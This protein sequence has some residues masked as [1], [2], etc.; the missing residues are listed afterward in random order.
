[1]KSVGS[2]CSV[3]LLFVTKVMVWHCV[4]NSHKVMSALTVMLTSN[5]CC[6]DFI[7]ILR[8]LL[9]HLHESFSWWEWDFLFLS[10][11]TKVNGACLSLLWFM[12]YTLTACQSKYLFQKQYFILVTVYFLR[13]E[14]VIVVSLA[15]CYRR[16]PLDFLGG[17]RSLITP[18]A[19]SFPLMSIGGFVRWFIG[20]IWSLIC[21]EINLATVVG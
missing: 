19:T 6:G 14:D 7:E 12:I 1:M 20:L 18:E 3:S 15:I 4:S 8:V 10:I 5:G 9:I 11:S 17:W 13:L 16:A 21:S 2:H